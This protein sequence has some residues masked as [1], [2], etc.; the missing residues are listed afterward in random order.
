M[1]KTEANLGILYK[2]QT[3]QK[4]LIMAG[5]KRIVHPTMPKSSLSTYAEILQK[6]S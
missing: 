4:K 2:Y 6:K 5:N 1:E 3:G